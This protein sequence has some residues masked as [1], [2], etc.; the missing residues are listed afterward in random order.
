M[1]IAAKVQK[2]FDEGNVKAI[3]DVIID[4]SFA[5]HGIRF[6]D[7]SKG[8]F[9]SMPRDKWKNDKGETQYT[10]IIH[11]I[12]AQTRATLF[13]AVETAYDNYEQNFE[14]AVLPFELN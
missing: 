2:T 4:D 14:D 10:D 3:C 11:P 5:I 9:I 13:K 8:R 6:V 12:N 7:G 1:K